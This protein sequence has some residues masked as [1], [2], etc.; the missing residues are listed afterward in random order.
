ME[1]SLRQTSAI[2]WRRV[3]NSM[4]QILARCCRVSGRP[5]LLTALLGQMFFCNE[6]VLIEKTSRGVYRATQMGLN[7][8]T[9]KPAKIDMA[10]L[11]RFPSYV[12]WRQSSET[13]VSSKPNRVDAGF[14]AGEPAAT[15]EEQIGQ[16][17]RILA[18]ALEADLLD[19]MR[20][21]SPGSFEQLVIDLLGKLGYGGGHPE[22]GKATGGPGDAGLDGVIN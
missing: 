9:E 20:E 3:Y 17:Y 8:L 5:R 10:F 1:R 21:M 2:G 6:R 19:R 13:P 14:H 16:S 18:G 22:R 12:E 15:P 7:I 4:A 11:E